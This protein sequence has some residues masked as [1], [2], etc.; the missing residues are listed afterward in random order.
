MDNNSDYTIFLEASPIIEGGKP[1]SNQQT[2]TASTAPSDNQTV[3][4]YQPTGWATLLPTI[5][6]AVVIIGA[7]YLLLFRPQRKQAKEMKTMQSNIRPGDNVVTSSGL[8]G[9]V[10]DVGEDVFVIEFGTNRGIRIPV[11]KSDVVAI[12]SPKLTPPPAPPK[13]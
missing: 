4:D 9:K 7:M 5:L 2:T 8:Y 13:E 1:S 12:K 10:M 11:S 3:D 6:Y